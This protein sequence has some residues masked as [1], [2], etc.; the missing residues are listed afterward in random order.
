[1]TGNAMQ[2]KL[3]PDET[4]LFCEQIAMVLKA[5]IPLDDGMETLARSYEAAAYDNWFRAQVQ[6]S[7]NDPRPSIPDTE[8]KAHF[9]AKRDALRKRTGM[10]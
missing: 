1:M 10:A 2:K 3:P 8:V 9:V 6:A 4:A 7:L 5:G